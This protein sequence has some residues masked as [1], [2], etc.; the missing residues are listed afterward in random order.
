MVLK[1]FCG[2]MFAVRTAKTLGP[3]WEIDIW[4]VMSAGSWGGIYV[5]VRNTL[6]PSRI[7]RIV[8]FVWS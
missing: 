4:Q 3:V 6:Y 2:N 8:A 7:E 1:Y 5:N